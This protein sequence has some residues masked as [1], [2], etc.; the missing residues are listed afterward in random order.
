MVLTQ[1]IM[2]KKLDRKSGLTKMQTSYKKFQ[3]G[4]RIK[5]ICQIASQSDLT[6]LLANSVSILKNAH[7]L[8]D[9]G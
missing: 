2:R 3:K 8:D 1:N 9:I 5:D 6:Q 7:T 4:T